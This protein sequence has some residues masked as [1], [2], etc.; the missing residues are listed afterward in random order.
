M[1]G[2]ILQNARSGA[3]K[4]SVRLEKAFTETGNENRARLFA[5]PFF[6]FLLL[7]LFPMTIPLPVYAIDTNVTAVQMAEAIGIPSSVI[8]TAEL[9]NLNGQGTA[10]N[11]GFAIQ[12]G[13]LGNNFPTEGG[14]F[15]ILTSGN[16]NDIPGSNDA[17]GVSFDQGVQDGKGADN[18]GDD[19][20]QLRI[21]IDPPDTAFSFSFQFVFLSEEFPEFVGSA[22]ND[23]FLVQAAE[24]PATITF[25]SSSGVSIPVASDN[26]VFDNSN[27]VMSVNNNFFNQDENQSTGTEFDGQTPLL[28][29]CSP[30]PNGADPFWLVFSIGDEG[31]AVLMSGVFIDGFQFSE[32]PL[33]CAT[34]VDPAAGVVLGEVEGQPVDVVSYPNPFRPEKGPVTF[35]IAEESCLATTAILSIE[36]FDISGRRVRLLTGDGDRTL[37]WDGRTQNGKLMG[38]GMY[39]Y[40]IY[41]NEK[42]VGT[43][44]FTLIH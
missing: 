19:V 33:C 25:D 7:F 9:T 5:V 11:N 41:D 24:N 10:D 27:K 3:S 44:R 34:T 29:T 1:S 28:L 2:E 12:T 37:V 35:A 31:D 6:F 26:I 39:F 20:V 36:I 42:R 8:V 4:R 40:R 15:V 21:K 16:V 17:T 43:G 30:L 18:G 13:S 14:S 22:F 32:Q 38:S 23:F